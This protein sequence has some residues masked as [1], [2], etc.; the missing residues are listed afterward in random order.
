MHLRTDATLQ[1]TEVQSFYF[2]LHVV[3]SG[4]LYEFS[5]ESPSQLIYIQG[6]GHY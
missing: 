4:F 2:K 6:A 5:R 1:L 3:D